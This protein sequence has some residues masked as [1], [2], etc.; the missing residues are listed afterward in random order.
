MRQSKGDDK[1]AVF[2]SA[3]RF[4]P[5]PSHFVDDDDGGGEREKSEIAKLI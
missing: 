3:S 5:P 2:F 1:F 4:L